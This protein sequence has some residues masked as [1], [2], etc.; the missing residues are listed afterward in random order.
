METRF[1]KNFIYLVLLA[2]QEII[3][4]RYR[5]NL[6]NKLYSKIDGFFSKYNSISE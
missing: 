5:R 3:R 6:L 4:I 1:K 2:F